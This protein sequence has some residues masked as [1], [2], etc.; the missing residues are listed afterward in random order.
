VPIKASRKE[1][2]FMARTKIQ[3]LQTKGTKGFFGSFSSRKQM[4]NW[5]KN[6]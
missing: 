6:K 2:N 4:R 3:R 5:S 1:K